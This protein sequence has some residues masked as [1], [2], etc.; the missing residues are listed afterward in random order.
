MVIQNSG[1]R[2]PSVRFSERAALEKRRRGR[3]R[4]IGGTDSLTNANKR[5]KYET[6]DERKF[7]NN[8]S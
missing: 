6:I 5:S 1:K 2:A 7:G 8:R 3:W 4:T